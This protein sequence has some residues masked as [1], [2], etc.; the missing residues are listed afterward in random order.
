[1]P[2]YLSNIPCI[3]ALVSMQ[4]DKKVEA[5]IVLKFQNPERE[6]KSS[7]IIIFQIVTPYIS[8]EN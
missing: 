1:M 6:F 4:F 7:S 8:F 2:M 5:K 3:N